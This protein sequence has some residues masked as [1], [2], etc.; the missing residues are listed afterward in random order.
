MGPER[1]SLFDTPNDSLSR[2]EVAESSSLDNAHSASVAARMMG[3]EATKKV[4]PETQTRVLLP[5]K[6]VEE[7]T[8][9]L[10]AHRVM[11]EQGASVREAS[12]A[13]AELGGGLR[14]R[15][16][17]EELP[18]GIAPPLVDVL[19]G[20]TPRAWH[21]DIKRAVEQFGLAEFS[22]RSLAKMPAEEFKYYALHFRS[23]FKNAKTNLRLIQAERPLDDPDIQHRYGANLNESEL[24]D[25]EQYLR[26]MIESVQRTHLLENIEERLKVSYPGKDSNRL[27]WLAHDDNKKYQTTLMR[28]GDSPRLV[29]R[30]RLK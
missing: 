28:E 13:Y 21:S 10:H 30:K 1:L 11:T 29:R 4:R 3:L 23:F 16:Q 8:R 20:Y 9:Q 12:D 2:D 27:L 15:E 22:A 14:Y 26:G 19:E 5:I 18:K 6:T 25:Y 24:K 17:V 7:T